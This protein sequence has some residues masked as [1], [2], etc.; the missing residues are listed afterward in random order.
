MDFLVFWLFFPIF[1]LG[2]Y[3]DFFMV[4]GIHEEREFPPTLIT[5]PIA[6][7]PNGD[8]LTNMFSFSLC[9]KY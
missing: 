2:L 9:A 7:R 8:F 5:N 6:E 3:D 1:L 4:C